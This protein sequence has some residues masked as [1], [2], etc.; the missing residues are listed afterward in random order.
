[1]NKILLTAA[2]LSVSAAL[3]AADN[4]LG[5]SLGDL[6]SVGRG[7]ARVD[8]PERIENALT[9]WQKMIGSKIVLWRISDMH[10]DHYETEKTGYIKWVNDKIAEMNSKFDG[11]K[12]G[13]EVAHKLGMKFYLNQS[14]NDGGWPREIEGHKVFYCWQDKDLIA[15]PYLQEVDKR[16][17]YHYGYLDL[18]NPEARKFAIDRMMKYM[19]KLKADGLYLN[20]RSHSGLYSSHVFSKYP[21]P[22]HADRFGFGKELVK[23]YKKRYGIDITKDPRFDYKDPKFAPKSIEVENWRKLR[24]EYFLTFYKEVKKALG[25]RGLILSL[26]LGNYMGSSGGNIYVDH[27]RIIKEKLG[28]I[29]VVGTS[30][31]FVPIGQQRKLGYLSSEA[32]EANYNVPSIEKYLEKYGKLAADKG[33]K[34]YTFQHSAYT[35]KVQQKID[36]IRYYAGWMIQ[37]LPGQTVPSVADSPALRPVKGVFSVEAIAKPSRGGSGR[38]ISKY[39]HHRDPLG[40]RGWELC[41]IHNRKSGKLE[42]WFRVF[43]RYPE[44]NLPP[45]RHSE[46]DLILKSPVHVPYGEWC[47][48]GGTLDMVNSKAYIYVNGKVTASVDIPKGAYIHQNKNIDLYIGTYAGDPSHNYRGLLDIIRISNQKIAEYN[49][50]PEY[51]GKEKGTVFFWQFNNKIDP[52]VK[53]A[54]VKMSYSIPPVFKDGRNGRKAFWFNDEP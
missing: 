29:L 30:S 5:L 8:T 35:P 52:V 6:Y 3:S 32:H 45:A 51:N 17:N 40:A 21:G 10:R 12:I 37:H 47:H 44:G 22:H 23:E 1:M 42:P 24:G 7:I 49:G 14:F 25:N 19:N 54:G 20:S 43:L 26:P 4:I 33:I 31:G 41:V 46:K 38:F 16:G 11:N 27:E 39:A 9:V 13:R 34:I 15:R 50:I 48:I 18:S 53:P 28:D 2:V 36:K